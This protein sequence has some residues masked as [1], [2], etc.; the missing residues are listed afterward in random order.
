M[1]FKPGDI[2][3]KVNEQAI[4]RVKDLKS[5]LKDI[6]L[7]WELEIRRAKKTLRLRIG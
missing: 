2:I 3:L 5:L 6:N 1:G 7:P 4:K